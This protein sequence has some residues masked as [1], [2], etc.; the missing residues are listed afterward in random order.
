MYAEVSGDVE[1]D[2]WVGRGMWSG[3]GSFVESCCVESRCGRC[4]GVV[5]N[6][7]CGAL[8]CWVRMWSDVVLVAE[9][10]DFVFVWSAVKWN[11]ARHLS[12]VVWIV[13]YG[14]LW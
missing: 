5:W 14:E 8:W 1:C 12:G 11:S 10:S 4:G 3:I 2:V 7:G 9:W 13:G 6:D